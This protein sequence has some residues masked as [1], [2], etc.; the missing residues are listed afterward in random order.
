MS[1]TDAIL[2]DLLAGKAITPKDALRDHRCM[3]L[4][5]VIHAL[6]E[7][8]FKIHAEFIIAKRRGD[9]VRY[10]S[11]TLLH[12]RRARSLIAQRARARAATNAAASRQRTTAR[13]VA[14]PAKRGGRRA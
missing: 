7:D 1:Q 13:R 3:R 4:A 12:R 14:K 5:A 9:P 10:A 11:Y 2:A 8:G 6:R